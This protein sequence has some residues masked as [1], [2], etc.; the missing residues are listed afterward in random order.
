MK[1]D[2]SKE[3]AVQ[4]IKVEPGSPSP[5]GATWDGK[6]VN[7]AL[8]SD[9]ATKVEVSLFDSK[10]AASESFRTALPQKTDKVWHGYFPDL[11]PGQLYGFRVHGPHEPQRGHRFNPNKLVL[12]PYAKA[13]GRNLQ[14]ND[15]L[16]GYQVGHAQQDLSFDERDSA[17]YAPLAIVTDPSF[18]W[19]KDRPLRIPWEKTILYE[20]HV[21]GFTKLH[22]DIPEPLRGT[23]RG[24]ASEVVIQYLKDLGITA[25]E[26]L[27]VHH[28]INNRH[29]I[30][31]HLTNY[32]G[33]NTLAYFA[34]HLPYASTSDGQESVREFKEMVRTFH[35]AGMEVILD[36]VYN[37]TAEGNR[38]GATLSFRGIDNLSYYRLLPN[39][40][41]FYEDVTG[42]GNT[43]N[44]PH[45]RVRELVVESLRYWVTEMHVDGF[46]F[47]LATMLARE[48][49]AFH[50]KS[51][52][53][54]AIRQDPVLSQV[55]L[56]A[57][58]WD[59]GK[60]GYQVGNFPT[61][62]AEWNGKYRDHVRRFWRG[63]EGCIGELA[64]RLSGS[65]DLYGTRRRTPQA[66]INFVTCHDGFTLE[67][68]VSYDQ[69]RNEANREN[70]RD[71]ANENFSWNGGAEGPTDDPAIR[72]LREKQKRNFMATLLLSQGIPMMSHGDEIGRTQQGNNN[73]YCQDNEIAWVNW[74]LSSEKEALLEFTRRMIRLRRNH[75]IFQRRKF[76]TEKDLLWF[77]PSGERMTEEAW[78]TPFVRCI[79][80]LFSGR[81][82][83]EETLLILINAHFEAIPFVLPREGAS[84]W[85]KLLDTAEEETKDF[86]SGGESYSL[87]GR[88]LV[89]FRFGK[90]GESGKRNFGEKVRLSLEGIK[91]QLRKLANL[92]GVEFSYEDAFHRQK[93]ASP[94]ALLSLL[95]TLGCPVK[96]WTD[97]PEALQV[98]EEAVW[99]RVAEPVLVGWEG[100]EVS[101]DL[102]LPSSRA[103]EGMLFSLTEESGVSRKEMIRLSEIP[104]VASAEFSGKRYFQ[105]RWVIPH[106]LPPGYHRVTL[107]ANRKRLT[108]SLIVAPPQ[109]YS[110]LKEPFSRT[111]GIFLPL[112]A[113][114]SHRN[115][116][117]GDF[118]DLKVL[119]Q[120][121]QGLG[122]SIVATLPLLPS[123]F[124]N[125]TL[126]GPYSPVS[127]LFW[128]EFYLDI[129][130]LPEL[131]HTPEAK[132]FLQSSAF[133]KKVG[134]L[135][136]SPCV[137]Y[138]E[139][140]ALKRKVLEQL[141][142]AFFR[143]VTPRR[144]EAFQHFVKE[145]GSLEEY[146]RFRATCEQKKVSW[147][148]WPQRMQ[149][150][151]LREADYD[152]S[153]MRYHLY[154]QWASEE[155]L[156]EIAEENRREGKIL[157]LDLPLGTDP[158]GYDVWRYKEN[159]VREVRV[160]A[161]P[162]PVFTT[163]QDWGF[164][165]LH[166]EVI[167]ER[168]YDYTL[169]CIRHHLRHA[170]LLR[171]DHVMMF[172]RLF[173]IPKGFDAR[174][175]CYVRY[176]AEE[177]YAI[178][179]LESHR[180]KAIIAGENLGTVPPEVNSA[181]ARH[182]VKRLFVAQYELLTHPQK[183]LQSIPLNVVASLNTHDMFPFAAFWEGAD[184]E[185][186]V[187]LGL[188]SKEEGES[189]K[190]SRQK[191][192]REVS[193]ILKEGEGREDESQKLEGLLKALLKFL[194]QSPAQILLIN[195]EDLWLER[196]P[197]N[198]PG[199][200]HEHPNWCR[201]TKDPFEVFSTSP[202][203][204]A[205]LREIGELRK[206]ES[207]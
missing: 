108:A 205:F 19:G 71:G 206:G 157:S 33:Y 168:E 31:R 193:E 198:I 156:K 84:F 99:K 146:A 97:I 169:A 190:G 138:R 34:P 109:A 89:L 79:G 166:P 164:P 27:P 92:Y 15:C 200:V 93:E 192:C 24:L 101:I 2:T 178:L 4:K 107:E 148:K 122:G 9:H 186:R 139:T 136:A 201:K 155:Q 11:K 70:N 6:G 121:V 82:A 26:L 126:P 116:G 25:V 113:L 62:W 158:D 3:I 147:E 188:L 91:S 185:A 152:L 135:R 180:Q 142:E 48:P 137:D 174:E 202:H 195:L 81:N 131:A 37:H 150:G 191:A 134:L 43:L 5:L 171:I 29:L 172:H 162:D 118:T 78:R 110:F 133:Q 32:W 170:G 151:S 21:K 123:F 12:D 53:F 112:Y 149:D 128:N 106:T 94:E 176:P 197:Q 140:M 58:P 80:A 86:F 66:S 194:S 87:Q 111:W 114:S 59:L 88:S 14:W 173:W 96:K 41:R 154:T 175:G 44:V 129:S 141:A 105:K 102:R 10:E 100:E 73:T 65:S 165:P 67:D 69:K 47:D 38:L 51:A 49:A 98:R 64:T 127:R 39:Q 183:A 18:S 17:P 143:G 104:T 153:A 63:D 103:E 181:M 36:V 167:R 42:C 117:S 50:P 75:P 16:F 182:N 124:D 52:F 125:E 28:Y 132:A 145:K 8:F 179:C 115:W 55:K 184:I 7:I 144:L 130:A 189:E 120:W 177:F 30:E 74:Q 77:Q 163:G 35:E 72:K 76:F 22:P 160:G 57:E 1:L 187:T 161:P 61:G 40:R 13:I 159:F 20:L 203:V 23:Y 207:R 54:D 119:L 45:P 196:D 95:K 90:E 68:L 83:L 60:G 204:V 46:R 56:I 85:E 199:T